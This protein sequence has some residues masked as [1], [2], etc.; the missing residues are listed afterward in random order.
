MTMTIG[1][2][3]CPSLEQQCDIEKLQE[4]GSEV[5]EILNMAFNKAQNLLTVYL[6]NAENIA[7]VL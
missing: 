1:P 4:F 5:G 6:A 7:R 3:E 2:C